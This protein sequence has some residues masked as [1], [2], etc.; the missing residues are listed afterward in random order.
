MSSSQKVADQ[1]CKVCSTVRYYTGAAPEEL[2]CLCCKKDIFYCILQFA[3]LV[4]QR[5]H[6]RIEQ[7]FALLLQALPLLS[8][9][10]LLLLIFVFLFGVAGMQLFQ[11]AAHQA[12]VNIVDNSYPDPQLTENS[13]EWGCGHR[14]CPANFTCTVGP[15]K[16]MMLFCLAVCFQFKAALCMAQSLAANLMIQ[17]HLD[18]VHYAP[19]C[20]LTHSLA[21]SLT[22]SL[23]H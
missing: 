7:D 17:A 11:N 8:S 22:R 15:C 21:H 4:L 16:Q 10:I 5:Q 12:C 3:S 13:D 20:S 23:T 19:T 1:V 6:Q 9:A 18:Q 2:A 14:H